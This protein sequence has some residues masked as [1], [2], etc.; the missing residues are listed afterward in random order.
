MGSHGMRT[1]F[2]S[3]T[4]YPLNSTGLT[5]R[6]L[7]LK[8]RPRAAKSYIVGAGIS[9]FL[10]LYSPS[11]TEPGPGERR[12]GRD[13][14]VPGHSRPRC[15]NAVFRGKTLLSG[16]PSPLWEHGGKRVRLPEASAKICDAC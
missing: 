6:K 12:R 11:V 2:A 15:S 5:V 4:N 8:N 9:Y 3:L 14:A 16:T 7:V 10:E 13:G 1:H